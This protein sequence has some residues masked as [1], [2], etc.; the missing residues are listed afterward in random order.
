MIAMA[1]DL[2]LLGPEITVLV[3]AAAALVFE[4]ARSP[5]GALAVTIAGLLLATGLAL[6]RIG[7]HTTVFGGTWR[8]D[9]LSIWAELILLPATALTALLVRAELPGTDREGTVYALLS[10]TTFGALALTASGDLMLL[11]LGLVLTGLGSFAL[12]AYPRDDR[13][14][15]AAMKFFVFGSVSGAIM[16]FGLSYGYGATGTTLLSGLDR[17]GAMPLAAALGLAG[18]LIGLGYEA[19]LA[20]FHF[21]APDAYDGAPVSVAAYLSIVPKVGALFALAQVVRDLPGAPVWQAA[22]AAL[23]ALSMTWGYLAA[24][25]QR[26]VVRLLAYSSIAQAGYFLLG[27]LAVGSSSLAIPSLVVFAAAYAAMNLGAFTITLETGR[28][29]EDFN[30]LGRNHAPAGIAMTVFLLSLTG[31]PPLAGFTGK[32]L[33]FG[34][35]LNAGYLW[36]AIV[37]ILNSVLSLAVYLGVI[38]PAYRPGGAQGH[39]SVPATT[40]WSIALLAT[41]AIGL[42]AQP[43]LAHLPYVPPT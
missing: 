14:T 1:H 22:L 3:T 17:L 36:L 32:A 23:A 7:L 28:H 40:A 11:T 12:V 5:R 39:R 26:N 30:G 43:L 6:P 35:T 20:P 27:V 16:I 18:V 38:V 31:I 10:L 34:A 33:L 37:A 15:E 24:L 42:A 25:G 19:S 4:M 2:S 29:L 8:I 13:A 9:E 21:W 41:L